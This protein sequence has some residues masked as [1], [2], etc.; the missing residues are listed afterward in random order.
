MRH[1]QVVLGRAAGPL[2]VEAAIGDEL[3]VRIEDR[4]GAQ[5]RGEHVR[6]GLG[7]LQRQGP[8]A[9]VPVSIDLDR[10][11]EGQPVGGTGISGPSPTSSVP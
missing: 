5:A 7:Q 2:S 1:V 8:Q 6:P 11:V 4:V 9:Q 3:A 10:L